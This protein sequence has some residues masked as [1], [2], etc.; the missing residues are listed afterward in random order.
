[1]DH[2]ATGRRLRSAK[3]LD[4][5]HQLARNHRLILRIAPG[6]RSMK[7]TRL[8]FCTALAS[9]AAKPIMANEPD[10]Q[11]ADMLFT[12]LDAPC[13]IL[14]TRQYDGQALPISAGQARE[15]FSTNVSGQGGN[16]ACAAALVGK[17]ALVL[18]LSAVSPTFPAKFTTMAYGTL[19]NG[20]EMNTGWT[21]GASLAS[22]QRTFTYNTPPFNLA[23]SIV[24]DQDTRLIT[25]LAVVSSQAEE[26]NIV[27]YSRGEAHYTLD[28][29]G[30][31][32]V[33]APE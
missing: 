15:V 13:R 31:Y 21:E 10:P 1:M 5:P 29:V 14:D 16:A 9:V 18:A 4:S 28:V 20:S 25:T 27:L 24:W 30:F 6:K 3:R 19:L 26:P 33:S 17:S 22:G 23:T 7:V 11:Y 32:E 12:A 8:L 2:T